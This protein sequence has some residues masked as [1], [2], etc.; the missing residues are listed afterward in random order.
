MI[1]KKLLIVAIALAGAFIVLCAAVKPVAKKSPPTF[2][3]AVQL[4]K[5]FEGMH[6]PKNWPYVGYGHR[7][8]SGE[9]Y[10]KGVQLS[11]K[12]ADALLRKD[13][14]KYCALYREFGADSLLL[15]ALAYNIGQGN[16]AKSSI[17]K[18]LRSGN[19]DIEEVY[20]AHCRYRGKV[21]SQIRRRR[22]AELE[23]LF[24]KDLRTIARK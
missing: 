18:K 2:E 17:L 6:T 16:V 4:I 21:N 20:I 19:R 22:L 12:Q 14:R 5:S 13:F 15:G 11:E 3:A 23:T 7:V 24:V 1:M 9:K 10:K 8:L